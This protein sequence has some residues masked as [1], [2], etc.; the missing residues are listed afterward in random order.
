MEALSSAT[1][2]LL[3]ARIVLLVI[4]LP[5]ELVL[6]M[7]DRGSIGRRQVAVVGRS[8]VVLFLVQGAFL[9]FQICCFPGGEF[10]TVHAVGNAVLLIFLALVDGL[11]RVRRG[12]RQGN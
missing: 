8:H 10:A 1:F 3:N 7:I 6:L 9:G 12:H 5:G 2:W 11:P 4:N